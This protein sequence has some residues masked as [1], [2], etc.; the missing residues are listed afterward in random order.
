MSEHQQVFLEWCLS[1]SDII[2][3]LTGDAVVAGGIYRLMPKEAQA[4]VLQMVCL[5]EG[6]HFTEVALRIFDQNRSKME[7][8]I[9]L[10][11]LQQLGNGWSLGRLFHSGIKEFM[12][13]GGQT[14][15]AAQ[16][17]R[18][19]MVRKSDSATNIIG[20]VD[21][22]SQWTVVLKLLLTSETDSSE[23]A[24]KLQQ[25][26]KSGGYSNDNGITD[27]GFQ[28]LMSSPQQQSWKLVESWLST[29]L[30]QLSSTDHSK[31]KQYIQQL[32]LILFSFPFIKNDTWIPA[33][34]ENAKRKIQTLPYFGLAC[35]NNA[36][37]MFMPSDLGRLITQPTIKR[38]KHC[39]DKVADGSVIVE[40]NN[41]VYCYS[42]DKY[43]IGMLKLLA[44]VEFQAPG[45]TV[46][47]LT[48]ESLQSAFQKNITS[49]QIIHYLE[50]N[51]HPQ[52]SELPS[53][54][55]DQ[56]RAWETELRRVKFT[57]AVL[58]TFSSPSHMTVVKAGALNAG[59]PRSAFVH[60]SQKFLA[61]ESAAFTKMK[62]I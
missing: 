18:I 1:Q 14:S 33:V 59:I 26:L 28:F 55:I 16:K 34:S 42:N 44:A 60:T 5:S 9:E 12:S 54:V 61:V 45:M 49:S 25:L 20:T 10:G 17:K 6:L 22:I 11:V 62:N 37:A 31:K 53:T 24:S 8:A 52:M 21:G 23:I 40:T 13:S 41:R 38:Q 29:Q 50:E 51:A 57:P 36:T 30:A 48:R 2:R 4:V 15:V 39:E 47:R 27:K 32:A 56:I 43:K 58:L 35:Y 19:Q 3:E 46:A 7:T